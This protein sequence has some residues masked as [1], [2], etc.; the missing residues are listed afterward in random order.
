MKYEVYCDFCKQIIYKTTT[1]PKGKSYHHVCYK[2]KQEGV[3]P[4]DEVEQVI[5]H[6]YSKPD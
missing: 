1:E 5:D 4:P 3:K 2:L 6:L